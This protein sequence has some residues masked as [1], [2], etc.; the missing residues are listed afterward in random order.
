MMEKLLKSMVV[1]A[2]VLCGTTS[3]AQTKGGTST[4]SSSAATAQPEKC[5]LNG[6]WNGWIGKNGWGEIGLYITSEKKADLHHELPKV[7][8]NGSI[9]YADEFFERESGCVLVFNRSLG[10]DA[11]EFT[12]KKKQGNQV[13]SGTVKISIS[14]GKASIFGLDAWSKQLPFHGVTLNPNQ[15]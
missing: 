5:P 15:M 10:N 3:M 12:V 9:S 11:Y 1:A 6:A 8:G 7:Q 2:L 13:K 4:A 14:D